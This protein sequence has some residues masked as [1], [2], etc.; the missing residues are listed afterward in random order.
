MKNKIR[1]ALSFLSRN[2]F[3]TKA[4]SL[5]LSI[6][7]LFYVIPTVVYGEIADAFSSKE[8]AEESVSSADAVANSAVNSGG[9]GHEVDYP[10]Y[11]V[12]ELREEK[13]KHFRLSDGS[14]VA[15]QYGSA[16]HYLDE[17]G[18]WQDIDNT[19]HYDGSE[20]LLTKDSRIKFSKKINGSGKV[21]SL[22]NGNYGIEISVIDGI[23]DSVGEVTS[24][25]DSEEATELQKML[26][27]EKLSSKVK[28]SEIFSGADMEFLAHS[29]S[30][31]KKIIVNESKESYIYSFELKLNGLNAA[32]TDRGD[33]VFT[34]GETD[35][36]VY[37]LPAPAAIDAYGSY[38][39]SGASN[40]SLSSNG[41]KYTLS[42]SVAADWM[43]ANSR[44]FP[45]E[46]APEYI[47]LNGENSEIYEIGRV[48][49]NGVNITYV[50]INSLPEIP[51][52][53]YL[54]DVYLTLSDDE[55]NTAY[56]IYEV[57]SDWSA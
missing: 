37:I 40:Y 56:G 25:T 55:P 53:A 3:A 12:M 7:L 19:L 26:Y 6:V 23:K 15:A 57:T 30:V 34:D 28:Y 4:L 24:F 8:R 2:K 50:K 21:L 33:V 16:V 9:A 27:L 1:K 38:A 49:S 18:A 31:E 5:T 35:E 13:A 42:V 45:V 14:Y 48:E 39:P 10:L 51:E 46:I 32:L 47:A 44:A 43:N 36:I 41:K 29:Q 54:S 11:E 20:N 52:S 22:K 17:S